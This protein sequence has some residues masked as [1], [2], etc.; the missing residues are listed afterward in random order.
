MLQPAPQGLLEPCPFGA[1]VTFVV[2]GQAAGANVDT[3]FQNCAS[4]QSAEAAL[5]ESVVPSDAARLATRP[6]RGFGLFSLG[7]PASDLKVALGP[8][9]PAPA[10]AA[11]RRNCR[12]CTRMYTSGLQVSLIGNHTFT[13]SLTVTYRHGRVARLTDN[14][15]QATVA[16]ADIDASYATLRRRLARWR[17]ITCSGGVR[18]LAHGAGP[19]TQLTFLPYYTTVSVQA[20]APACP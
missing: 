5:W 10:P 7:E 4:G 15:P 11:A 14:N 6:D 19:S 17:A 8:G 16:G 20:A 3:T 1:D 18:L 13:V 2:T 12:T 9:R